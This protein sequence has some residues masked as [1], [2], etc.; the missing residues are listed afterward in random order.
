VAVGKR[1]SL[2]DVASMERSGFTKLPNATTCLD[3]RSQATF[4]SMFYDYQGR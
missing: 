3:L 4:L 1:S 2:K